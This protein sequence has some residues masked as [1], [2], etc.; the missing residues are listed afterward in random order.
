MDD[1]NCVYE[2]NEDFDQA[3]LYRDMSRGGGE[4]GM[5]WCRTFSQWQF[6]TEFTVAEARANMVRT[7]QL[8]VFTKVATPAR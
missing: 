1:L 8:R 5:Y 4:A 7:K 6:N 2:P 3:P